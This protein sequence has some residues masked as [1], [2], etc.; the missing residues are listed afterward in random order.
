MEPNNVQVAFMS[1]VSD[2]TWGMDKCKN[3]MIFKRLKWSVS[4]EERMI[5]TLPGCHRVSRTFQ[6][7]F[8]NIST[9][10]NIPSRFSK[11]VS[12]PINLPFDAIN[13]LVFVIL[14]TMYFWFIVSIIKAHCNFWCLSRPLKLKR[15][16]RSLTMFEA[17][18]ILYL[19]KKKTK[20]RQGY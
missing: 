15:C 8:P 12:V 2:V 7:K 5:R 17:G 20:P 16:L 9:Y 13:I 6:K 11:T 3:H 14:G 18:S 10:D 1:M 4:A 19:K